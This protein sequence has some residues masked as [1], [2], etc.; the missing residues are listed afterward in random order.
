MVDLYKI[1]KNLNEENYEGRC[2][3][4]IKDELIL[5]MIYYFDSSDLFVIYIDEDDFLNENGDLDEENYRQEIFNEKRNYIENLIEWEGAGEYCVAGA[6]FGYTSII[7]VETCLKNELD[8]VCNFPINLDVE[9][10]NNTE[11]YIKKLKKEEGYRYIYFVT[12]NNFVNNYYRIRFVVYSNEE[13]SDT[14]I[15][16]YLYN[17][18]GIFVGEFSQLGCNYFVEEIEQFDVDLFDRYNTREEYDYIY[19]D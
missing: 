13:M 18:R 10:F 8:D 7:K 6:N 16:E 17:E 4:N 3:I 19:V 15:F 2:I 11:E 12:H 9:F 5:T 14:E 1:L